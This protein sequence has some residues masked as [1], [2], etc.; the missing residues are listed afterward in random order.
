MDRGRSA[1]ARAK[2]YA[3]SDDDIRK[4]LGD[5]IS[6]HSYADLSKHNKIPFDSKGRCVLLYLTFGPTS[7]HW[8][9]MLNKPDHIE[10]FDPYGKRPEEP[11]HQ[12]SESERQQYGEGEPYLTHLLR[13]SGKPVYYNTHQFQST[14]P[15][16]AECGRHSIV[17]CLYAPYSLEKYKSLI[18]KSGLTPDEFVVGVT[19]DK[20]HK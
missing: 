13:T 12:I 7:G 10:Y 20:L 9:C 3:L 5:D 14:K 19:F 16:N 11:L 4:I 17:R 1:L 18:D 6:I 8:V 15:G 2:D